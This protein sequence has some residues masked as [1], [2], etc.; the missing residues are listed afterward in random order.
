MNLNELTIKEAHKGLVNG[1]FS[2]E[3]IT[4]ACLERVEKLNPKLNAFITICNKEALAMAKAADKK[5]KAKDNVHY[6]TGLPLSV[7]DVICTKGIRTTGAAKILD[8]YVPPYDATVIKKIK[9]AGGV[10]VGKTNCDAFGHGASNENSHYGPVKNPWDTTK[11]SGGS[12]GGS[13]VS[14]ATDQCIYSLAEDTGG[15]IR[16]PA[17]FNNIAG[18]KVSY[19]RNSR[20]GIMPMASSLDTVG[21]MAK[22]V[23][24]LAII[25][26]VMAGLDKNDSTTVKNK[27]PE[28]VDLINKDIKGMKLGLPR[29]YLEQIEDEDTKKAIEAAVEKFKEMGCQVKE[30]S[31]PHT[32]YAIAVYYIIVPSEDS[33][34]LA[35]LD[36]MRYGVRDKKAKDLMETYL[37]SRAAGFPDEV[38]R[39]IMVGTY[40]LSSGYYDAYY[41]KAQ[42]VRTLIK[43]EFDRVFTDV[44][45][46][47][48]PTSP[49]PAFG[50]GEKIDDLLQMYLADVMVGPAS[51]A[52]INA[53]S[54]P[55]GFSKDLP[56]GMQII[57][58]RMREELV[59]QVGHAYEKATTWHK[60]KPKM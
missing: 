46:L 37:K 51:V 39:R 3:E 9:D 17:A 60:Q 56:V 14:V 18:L 32:K 31:L 2:S 33:A 55:C 38:K 28:Y 58:P 19:G 25:E 53:L 5:I 36:G 10:I 1:D 48:T 49:F 34:N 6:L 12:S 8:N 47:I 40:A 26:E 13:A 50:I 29:E 42:K 43:N 11:V 41:L 27:V 16:Q 4:K 57:G 24:D 15:S 44:D 45:F 52:G 30:V 20:Y 35:R 59:L 7:K 54:V 21:P 23:E 22:T